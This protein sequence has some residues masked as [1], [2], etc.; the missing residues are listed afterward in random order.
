MLLLLIIIRRLFSPW[1]FFG[2][3][4][5]R[6]SRHRKLRRSF[7]MNRC[8]ARRTEERC[9]CVWE[10]DSRTH[11][12]LQQLSDH[13]CGTM[14]AGWRP[15]K[16]AVFLV[17]LSPSMASVHVWITPTQASRLVV[18]EEEVSSIRAVSSSDVWILTQFYDQPNNM[19]IFRYN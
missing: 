16:A 14:K 4:I 5:P 2:L 9:P 18:H 15:S 12:V 13:L 19:A 10:E 17:R 8:K 6:S 3:F 7:K 1:P 11:R